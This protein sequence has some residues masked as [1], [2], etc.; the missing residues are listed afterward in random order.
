MRLRITVSLSILLFAG[1][2]A[3][4]QHNMKF[5]SLNYAGILEGEKAT[6][7]QVQTINGVKCKTWFAGLGAGIDYYFYRSIPLFVSVSKFLPSEKVP[8]YFSGDAGLNFPWAKSGTYQDQGNAHSSL[9]WAGS[10]GYVLKLKGTD[11]KILFNV[12]YSYKHIIDEKKYFICPI[13]PPCYEEK[14]RFDYHLKRIS[15]KAGWMF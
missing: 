13:I 11:S 7:F 2:F 9:F 12:G 6:A 1:R 10:A 8:L 3:L 15:V 14:Q 5:H 4:A